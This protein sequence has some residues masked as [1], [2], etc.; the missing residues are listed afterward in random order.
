MLYFYAIR[1]LLGLFYLVLILGMFR[2]ERSLS[3]YIALHHKK[4]LLE[5]T[6]SNLEAGIHHLSQ[7]IHRIENSPEYAQRILRD[8]YHLLAE[9]EQ[10]IL[11]DDH[12]P[13]NGAD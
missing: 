2:G 10:L 12:S 3:N 5:T 7:E 11:F 4:K 8:K 13:L 6:V 1:G 9:D